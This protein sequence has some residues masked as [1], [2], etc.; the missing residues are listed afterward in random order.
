M[1]A[2]AQSSNG[3]QVELIKKDNLLKKN[4][5]K[6]KS[7]TYELEQLGNKN[8]EKDI[9]LKEKTA[10]IER[11]GRENAEL[12]EKYQRLEYTVQ[13]LIKLFWSLIWK[14]QCEV[15]SHF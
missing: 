3:M 4:E 6:R 12:T 2:A 9:L 1:L 8:K 5:A 13:P 11:L 7:M 10:E 15:T 14:Q